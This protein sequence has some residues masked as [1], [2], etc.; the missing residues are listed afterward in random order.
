MRRPSCFPLSVEPASL[1]VFAH[2][3]RLDVGQALPALARALAQS[4]GWPPHA[5]LVV[6]PHSRPF[7]GVLGTFSAA[8]ESWLQSQN[9]ALDSTCRHLR[10]IDFPQVLAACEILAERLA[11][12]LGAE[13]VQNARFL[14]IPRGGLI[15]LGLLASRLQLRPEQLEPDTGKAGDPDRLHVVVDD[16][17][18]T[19]L[20]FG[21]LLRRS[22][23]RRIVFAPLYSPQELR[24]NLLAREPRVQACLSAGEIGPLPL[25][26]DF[27]GWPDDPREPAETVRYWI[28]QPEPIAFPWNEP[29]RSLW[30]PVLERYQAAWHLVP[31]ELCLK[32]RLPP[33]AQAPTVQIQPAGQ[34][35][36]RPAGNVLFGEIAGELVLCDLDSGECLQ[37]TGSGADLWQALVRHGNLDGIVADLSARY[38]APEGKLRRD[39]SRFVEELFARGL[40]ER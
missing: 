37:L 20:R 35:E 29:D 10:F 8:E 3:L 21:Q 6:R 27:P 31:P 13:S 23:A 39:A 24:Q 33:G 32:N 38:A 15:V 28:G 4:P 14:A 2:S 12:A 16:C 18:L 30:N 17:A 26:P 11:Q 36:I 9:A 1:S 22:A 40:L 5:T 34:G 25:P 7:L 19:G